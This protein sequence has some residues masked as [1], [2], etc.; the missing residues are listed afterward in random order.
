MRYLVLVS[1]SFTVFSGGKHTGVDLA[2]DLIEQVSS[3]VMNNYRAVVYKPMWGKTLPIL[4]AQAKA[5]VEELWA[6]IKDEPWA[7]TVEIDVAVAWLGNELVGERG[8]F[9]NPA[10]E[11][12]REKY[13]GPHHASGDWREIANRVCTSISE[14]TALRGRPEF[15]GAIGIT[16]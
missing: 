11:L 8:L 14:L 4:V 2:G 9:L 10:Y 1:D 6:G 16:C 5:A 7:S 12:W 15:Q 3:G 13:W